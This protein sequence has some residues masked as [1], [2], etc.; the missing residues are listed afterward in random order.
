MALELKFKLYRSGKFPRM[1]R[2]SQGRVASVHA[3]ET[4]SYVKLCP[5]PTRTYL[6]LSQSS[7]YSEVELSPAFMVLLAVV[8]S[9]AVSVGHKET[10]PCGGATV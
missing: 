2:L 9:W 8:S 1:T 4:S 3:G 5:S 7:T 6:S 10:V